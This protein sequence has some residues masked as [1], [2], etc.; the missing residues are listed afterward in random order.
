MSP[1]RPNLILAADIP[2]IEL[3]ILVGY[4]LD[5]EADGR[6]GGDVLIEL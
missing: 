3:D 1:Q 2:H 4:G 5:V 6:N